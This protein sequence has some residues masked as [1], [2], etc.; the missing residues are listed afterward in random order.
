VNTD[1]YDMFAS[2]WNSV[3]SNV[4]KIPF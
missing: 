4:D 1:N 3:G 2:N